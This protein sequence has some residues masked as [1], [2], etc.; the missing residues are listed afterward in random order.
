MIHRIFS[1]LAKFKT[2][3]FRPGFN[4][5]L[6]EKSPNARKDQTRNAAGKST[7]LEIIHYLLGA[8]IENDSIFLK[9]MVGEETFG[10]TFDC[11]NDVL[12]VARRAAPKEDRSRFFF[13]GT[14]PAA[15]Q[16]A[17]ETT[18]E[19]GHY[20]RLKA[21]RSFLGAQLFG[22]Q[23]EPETYEPTFRSL[24]P[25]FCRRGAAAFIEPT[26]H[27]SQQQPWEQNVA[28]A[29]FLGLD[30]RIHGN[31][32][33][34]HKREQ[35]LDQLKRELKGGSVVGELIG[36]GAGLQAKLT[37]AR[38]RAASFRGQLD[39]FKV[40]PQYEEVEREASQMANAIAELSNENTLDRRLVDDLEASLR[41]E[42]PPDATNLEHIYQAAGI[43]LPG[44]ALKRLE[45]VRRFHETILA[46]RRKHLQD[47]IN[48]AKRRI[49]H[50]QTQSQQMDVR[51]EQLMGLL[52]THGALDQFTQLQAE[53]SRLDAEVEELDRRLQL[54]RRIE[55]G[56]ADL[57]VER[58][59]L[60]RKLVN[61]HNDR[62]DS[63]NEAVLLFEELS[64]SLSERSSFLRVEPSEQGLE[65]AIEGGPDAKSIGIKEQQ[66]FCF[67]MMLAVLQGQKGNS[68]GFLVH[69]SHL[70]DAM[71]ERQIAKAFEIGAS[72]SEKHKFQYI[73]TLNDDRVPWS[74][75]SEGFDFNAYVLPT[76][77]SDATEDGGLLGCRLT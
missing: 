44:I 8:N 31:M 13:S 58:A 18:E 63:I 25:Y 4:V 61:D 9:P 20:A 69:D 56:S 22:L 21:W 23:P 2:Q 59:E 3:E 52:K 45:D 12:T 47:E 37:V 29:Y 55:T 10:M 6:A 64:C 38:R 51:R 32:A 34:L 70:F 48:A 27:S 73:V 33:R 75:F 14:V 66:I 46:N 39:A 30:W 60:H 5:L 11:P 77:L 50:R 7:V 26:R 24:F 53:L 1:S 36:T 41:E 72:L 54:A 62:A 40:L 19:G 67:D 74:E 42:Q 35:E 49:E 68:P 28:V 17:L 65:V 43:Q 76:R 71:E 57:K 15:L 16:D